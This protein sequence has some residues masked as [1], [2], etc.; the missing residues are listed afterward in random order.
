MG[1]GPRC[2]QRR[3]ATKAPPS[4]PP[5]PL[6]VR[7]GRVHGTLVDTSR[8]RA[9]SMEMLGFSFRHHCVSAG[10]QQGLRGKAVRSPRKKQMLLEH[11]SQPSREAPL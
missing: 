10:D 7:L 2:P 8:G 4:D 11:I 5:S 9:S 6:S 3:E 1:R